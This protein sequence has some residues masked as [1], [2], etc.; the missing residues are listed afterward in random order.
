MAFARRAVVGPPARL[1][2]PDLE[3]GGEPGRDRPRRR[4]AACSAM[5]VISIADQEAPGVE[6]YEVEVS[7]SQRDEYPQVFTEIVV[8]ARGRGP[9]LSEARSAGRS[10]CRRRSTARSTRWSRA[11]ATDGPSPVRRSTPTGAEPYEA[12]GEVVATGPYPRPDIL[13]DQSLTWARRIPSNLVGRSCLSILLG[14]S[15][16][17]PSIADPA[18]T[19]TDPDAVRHP[20]RCRRPPAE[21]AH[22]RPAR[23]SV[24]R[25]RLGGPADRGLPDR[26][27][28]ARRPSSSLSIGVSAAFGLRYSIYGAIW[29][30]IV[31]VAHLGPAEPEHEYPPRFAQV[32][33]S[34]A[35]TLSLRVVRSSA[36]RRS[37]GSSPSR[38]PRSRRCS[39]TTGYC[40]GCRLY[41]L[42]WWVPDVVT[43]IWTRGA[44]ERQPPRR[45]ADP[46]PTERLRLHDYAATLYSHAPM[47]TVHPVSASHPS[48]P[49]VSGLVRP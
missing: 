10:S 31:K 3:H 16:A 24:R 22:D 46:L 15:D 42:R 23:P 28:V 29:R 49:P 9:D 48:Q 43:R 40:L 44:L 20:H 33:G 14:R 35:L 1:R 7:G 39:A 6:R 18:R 8:D 2:R 32:L 25:R 27:A 34:V 26:P 41:F 37:A 30:R 45:G 36:R 13:A 47:T 4:S 21:G 19:R 38:S 5:D 11:G 17:A 12:E